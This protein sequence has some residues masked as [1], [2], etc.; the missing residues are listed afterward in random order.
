MNK[1]IVGI[2]IMIVF[3][4][5]S[6]FPNIIG[7]FEINDKIIKS[8]G[9]VDTVICSKDSYISYG[10]DDNWG[11]ES[12]LFAEQ[13]DGGNWT[14][15]SYLFFDLSSIPPD[16][17]I[18]SATLKLYGGGNN[19]FYP[20]NINFYAVNENWNEYTINYYNAPGWHSNPT[21]YTTFTD[22]S[23]I[24]IDVTPFVKDWISGNKE[25][26]GFI[27]KTSGTL[28]I[29]G[30]VCSHEAGL[31]FAPRLEIEYNEIPTVKII[32]PNSGVTINGTITIEGDAA[33]TEGY[34][35]Y[36]QIK[37][38]D[39][40]WEYACYYNNCEQ[41][42]YSFNSTQVNNGDCRIYARSFD[43]LD[44]SEIDELLVDVQ[45][46]PILDSSLM[47]KW[48]EGCNNHGPESLEFYLNDT[49]YCYL[50][51]SNVDI[52][53]VF[54]TK[55]KINNE[56][57]YTSNENQTDW[58]NSGCLWFSWVPDEI[59][60][61]Q[62]DI[63]C[64]DE[65]IGSS[66]VFNI[67]AI[68]YEIHIDSIGGGFGVRASIFNN[69]LESAYDVNWFID[70]E[71]SIGILLSGSHTSDVID[72]IGANGIVNI[73]STNL[74]GIGFITITVQAADVVKQATAFLLGP[75]VLRFTEE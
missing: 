33:D 4:G 63:F 61:W 10:S 67:V 40:N 42:N 52:G 72:E 28:Q 55:W 21:T 54:Y 15:R 22:D 2:F 53:D 18:N 24:L 70:I 41:W 64:D 69:G 43:G 56:V 51:V 66:P 44:Y 39:G 19:S 48:V 71:A 3:I 73:Q 50:S 23:W 57:R 60:E 29:H 1:K 47:C 8:K 12:W 62:V 32:S 25:N 9:E 46:P 11:S 6:F 7:T 13:F 5:I 45:N 17:Y 74:R 34:I 38:N 16:R 49:C 30:G 36:V 26:Y 31:N 27:F 58:G 14:T 35:H 37:I 65:Y 68:Q 20:G 75:L 59:G